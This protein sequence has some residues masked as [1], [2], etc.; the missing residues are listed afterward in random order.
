MVPL[1]REN[2]TD[3]LMLL[4]Y[5]EL[6]ESVWRKDTCAG[7]R[8]CISI[9]PAGTLAYNQRINRPY[10]VLPCVEC[11]ACLDACPRL[12]SNLKSL[13]SSDVL[14]SYLDINNVRAKTG[15]KHFQNGGAATA[16][17][18]AALEEELVDAALIMGMDRWAQTASP[19]VIYDA[20]DLEKCAGSKYTSNAILEHIM[21]LLKNVNHIALVGTPCTVQA[22]GLMRRSS[23]EFA[24]KLAHKVRFLLGLF[25]FDAFDGSLI[26]GVTEQM[27]IPSWRIDKMSAGD[28]KMT[29]TLRDGSQKVIPLADI[30]VHVKP[31]CR[32]CGDFTAKL[33]DISLGSIGSAPGMSVAVIRTPEGMGLFKIAEETGLIEAWPGVRTDV[34]E[35]VGKIKLR[36]NGYL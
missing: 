28:G 29:I 12:P 31:G 6:E 9:C 1:M 3:K 14:G 19:R 21:D 5:Q 2:N 10:Q 34:V 36:R 8:A 33:S 11:N 30:A 17:L 23:N 20:K 15:S 16:L 7:C 35:K 24:V 26:Q 27:G 4:P 18:S 13:D 22:V 32:A 25:C